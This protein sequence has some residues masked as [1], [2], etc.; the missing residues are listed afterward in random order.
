MKLCALRRLISRPQILILSSQNQIRGTLLLSRNELHYFR[1]S[2]FLQCLI[3]YGLDYQ[4]NYH[5]TCTICGWYPANICLEENSY[6]ISFAF[7]KQLYEIGPW[8]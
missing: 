7:K 2:G 5:V 3:L 4:P 6:P 8:C 1:G